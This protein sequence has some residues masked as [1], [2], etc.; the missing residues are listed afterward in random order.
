VDCVE[1][2]YTESEVLDVSLFLFRVWSTKLHEVLHR[3]TRRF[4]KWIVLMESHRVATLVLLFN[5]K[6]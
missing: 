4:L 6:I 1:E 5:G 2:R 3:D